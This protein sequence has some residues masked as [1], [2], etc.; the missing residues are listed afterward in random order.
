MELD[1]AL[2]NDQ[3]TGAEV[4]VTL[5]AIAT[6][7]QLFGVKYPHTFQHLSETALGTGELN[8]QDA[9]NALGWALEYLAEGE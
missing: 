6:Q 2:D 5:E 7:L 1:L 3:A 8:L 9:A 4:L